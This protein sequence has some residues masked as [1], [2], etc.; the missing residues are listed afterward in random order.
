MGRPPIGKVAMDAAER[1]R[2]HRARLRD[3][4][5]VT[6]PD[7]GAEQPAVSYIREGY[8]LVDNCSDE[9]FVVSDAEFG[10][11][12]TEADAQRWAAT[13]EKAPLNPGTWASLK[14]ENAKL[15]RE[16]A[17]LNHK[18][19]KAPPAKEPAPLPR[20]KTAKPP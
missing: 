11:F 14:A 15:K 10:P 1:Q 2:R 16:L 12:D 18:P 6:K 7:T 13:Q 17:A 19:V 3:M 4:R 9:W 5:P 20:P 8:L